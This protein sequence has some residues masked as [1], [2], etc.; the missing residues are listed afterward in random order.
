MKEEIN[1][2]NNE[3]DTRE[4]VVGL[5]AMWKAFWNPE[6]K[7][8]SEIEEI[9]QDEG[10]SKEMKE[11]LIKSLK[12]ADRIVKPTDG[13]SSRNTT[14]LKVDSK[15]SKEY[16]ADNPIHIESKSRNISKDGKEIGE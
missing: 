9:M 13:G 2:K 11:L 3:I 12:N 5:L 16:L 4:K 10:L 7:E 8:V 15:E 14:R 1:V 6:P